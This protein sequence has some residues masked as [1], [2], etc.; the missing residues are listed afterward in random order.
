MLVN[1]ENT[2]RLTAA[3]SQTPCRVRLRQTVLRADAVLLLS[4]KGTVCIL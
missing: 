1:Q 4:T 2:T 3:L